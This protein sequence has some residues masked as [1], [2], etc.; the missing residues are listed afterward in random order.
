MEAKNAH[1]MTIVSKG[2]TFNSTPLVHQ[3]MTKTFFMKSNKEREFKQNVR[4]DY[5]PCRLYFLSLTYM[6]VPSF[7]S[8]PFVLSK[9]WHRQQSIMKKNG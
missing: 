5:G 4:Y 7:I 8:I 6:Y 2:K 1:R 9:I 3:D